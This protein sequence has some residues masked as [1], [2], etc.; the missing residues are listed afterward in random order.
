VP[1]WVDSDARGGRALTGV[2][3]AKSRSRLTTTTWPPARAQTDRA[4]PRAR[5]ARTSVPASGL[6]FVIGLSFKRRSKARLHSQLPRRRLHARD[7]ARHCVPPQTSVLRLLRLRCGSLRALRPSL[8]FLGVLL[9]VAL[10]FGR[11]GRA[12]PLQ[13]P[14]RAGVPSC[15]A[16]GALARGALARRSALRTFPTLYLFGWPIHDLLHLQK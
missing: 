10:A 8:C 15:A 13:V 9:L 14:L 11:L 4:I 6:A 3:G 2:D 12:V 5:A 7:Q 16:V 1:K